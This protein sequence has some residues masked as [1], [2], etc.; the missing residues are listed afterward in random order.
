MIN[1]IHLF[2]WL[3]YQYLLFDYKTCAEMPQ[4]KYSKYLFIEQYKEKHKL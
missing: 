4:I 3:Y 1:L 2:R